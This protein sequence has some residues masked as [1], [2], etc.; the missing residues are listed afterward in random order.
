[1]IGVLFDF[2]GEIVEVRVNGS[3]C[4]F[5]TA[6]FGGA[7]ST[8][9]GL[10]LDRKGVIREFPDLEDK[11]DWKQE[12]I[13]RFKEKVK[14]MKSEAE[15]IE[16]VINDLKKYGYIPLYLQRDGQRPKKLK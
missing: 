8:I 10:K 7:F 9:D 11:E 13:K 14:A 5:R 6:R 1:M 4:Y 12:A 2:A 3:S 15:I 16:Y